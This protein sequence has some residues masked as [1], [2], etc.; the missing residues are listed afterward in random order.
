MS[1]TFNIDLWPWEVF[2][3]LNITIVY[4]LKTTG[5]NLMQFYTL[6]V[7]AMTCSEGESI[8]FR[9]GVHDSAQ[10]VRTSLQRIA[11]TVSRGYIVGPVLLSAHRNY[12]GACCELWPETQTV[13]SLP[14]SLDDYMFVTYLVISVYYYYFFFLYLNFL[15]PSG[16]K[17]SRGLKAKLKVKRKA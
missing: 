7:G 1:V 16:V 5:H 3:Y 4:N 17:R 11:S 12:A 6:M 2:S 15:I 10:V 13:Y 8:S 9:R 14:L